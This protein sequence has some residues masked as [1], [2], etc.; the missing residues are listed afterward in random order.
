MVIEEEWFSDMN[1]TDGETFLTALIKC[2]KSRF[3]QK[4]NFPCDT[5]RC[6]RYIEINNVCNT[7]V[8]LILRE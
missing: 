3:N 2:A 1:L 5:K 8:L 7:Q 4:I 6:I